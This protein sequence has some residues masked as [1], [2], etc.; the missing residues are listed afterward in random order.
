[1]RLN[2]KPFLAEIRHFCKSYP[3]QIVLDEKKSAREVTSNESDAARALFFPT[4]LPPSL[5]RFW[6]EAESRFAACSEA[7]A[8]TGRAGEA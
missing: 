5:C 3:R 7:T 2:S 8:L 6:N 4:P 1:M